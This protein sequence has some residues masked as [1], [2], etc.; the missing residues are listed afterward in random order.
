M[1]EFQEEAKNK[2]VCSV[3]QCHQKYPLH[4]CGSG[5]TCRRARLAAGRKAGAGERGWNMQAYLGPG[6]R[7]SLL[8][9]PS[10]VW[11]SGHSWDGEVWSQLENIGSD[12]RKHFPASQ[13]VK[14]ENRM[15]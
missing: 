13:A 5:L 9:Q 14:P 2:C 7:V 8:L 6:C 12:I 10:Q 11:P 15:V 1:E 4:F 3:G